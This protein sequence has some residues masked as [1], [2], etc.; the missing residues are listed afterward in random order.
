MGRGQ[1]CI[2]TTNRERRHDNVTY[3]DEE[4]AQQ[5]GSAGRGRDRRGTRLLSGS[6]KATTNRRYGHPSQ[7]SERC[8]QEDLSRNK[9]TRT[10]SK[11]QCYICEFHKPSP[12]TPGTSGQGVTRNTETRN[13][14]IQKFCC[15][16]PASSGSLVG[17]SSRNFLK[18]QRTACP[19]TE[20]KRC[21]LMP[22]PPIHSR[23]TSVGN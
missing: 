19:C 15:R 16:L 6:M 20:W 21:P 2:S 14:G 17:C 10:P 5:R 23:P 11:H 7:V 1:Q 8:V 9:V 13:G 3:K 18:S 22:V 12:I 4:K